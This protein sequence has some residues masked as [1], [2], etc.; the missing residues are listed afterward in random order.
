MMIF[1]RFPSIDKAREFAAAVGGQAYSERRDD[2]DPFPFDLNPPVVYV[3]RR[4]SGELRI[5]ALATM[6][7]GEFAGT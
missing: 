1:D 3:P 2:I 7:G 4:E 5:Q 6:F